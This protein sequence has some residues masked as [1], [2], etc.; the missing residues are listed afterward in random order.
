V[1]AR[2]ADLL[3]RAASVPVLAAVLAEIGEHP[4]HDPDDELRGIALSVLWPGHL[5]ADILATSLTTP[6]QGNVLGAYYIFRRR[7][8]DQLSDDSVLCLLSRPLSAGGRLSPDD[9]EL[10][11]GLLDR[12]FANKDTGAVIGPA[13]GVAAQCLRDGRYPSLPTALEMPPVT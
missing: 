13:A 11:E 5:T 4:D 12:G 2:T 7:L 6:Q 10:A 9:G 8:P 1:A 3:N